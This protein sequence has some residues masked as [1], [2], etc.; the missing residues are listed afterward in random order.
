[1]LTLT[2]NTPFYR[3]IS[4]Q[5]GQFNYFITEDNTGQWELVWAIANPTEA[6]IEG[7]NAGTIECRLAVVENIPFFCFRILYLDEVVIPWQECPF[8]GNFIP[9]GQQY[10]EFERIAMLSNPEIRIG[11]PIILI[12]YMDFIIKAMRYS[13]LSPKFSRN[14]LDAIANCQIDKEKEYHGKLISIYSRYPINY[15]SENC[16][17]SQCFAGD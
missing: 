17:I 11:L 16:A 10:L 12:D 7:I 14:L 6:E 1:M 9:G 13:S 15:I 2:L 3:P 4:E 5:G 8:N